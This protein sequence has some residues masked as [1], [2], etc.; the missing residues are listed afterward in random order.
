L[1][2]PIIKKSPELKKILIKLYRETFNEKKNLFKVMNLDEKNI[3]TIKTDEILWEFMKYSATSTPIFFVNSIYDIL[4]F[5]DYK[6][7]DGKLDIN[8]FRCN[9]PGTLSKFNWSLKIPMSLENL[10]NIK[11]NNDIKELIINTERDA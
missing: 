1:D 2:N 5:N 3:D 6:Y 11:A 7:L 10:Q 4:L 8:K 9:A